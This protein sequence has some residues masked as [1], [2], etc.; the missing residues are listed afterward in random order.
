MLCLLVVLLVSLAPSASAQYTCGTACVETCGSYSCSQDYY[1]DCTCDYDYDYYGYSSSSAALSVGAIIGIIV[2]AIVFWIIVC[3]LI[4]FACG[5]CCFQRPVATYVP[6]PA[7]NTMIMMSPV[8]YDKGPSPY[9]GYPPNNYAAPATPYSQN[10]AHTSS[11]SGGYGYGNT[12][13][14]PNPQYQPDT[15]GGYAEGRPQPQATTT[16]V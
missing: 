14:A 16:A 10:P 5:A 2:G 4:C 9:P 12:T 11:Y 7:A 8:G 6:S 15:S 1:G 13:T 3:V